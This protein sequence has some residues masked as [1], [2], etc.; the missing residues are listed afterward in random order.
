MSRAGALGIVAA[1]L[2]AAGCLVELA[3]EDGDRVL[4]WLR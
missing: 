2:L 3:Q 1:G 4:V